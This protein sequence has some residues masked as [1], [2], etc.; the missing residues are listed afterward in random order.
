LP[1]LETLAMLNVVPG[2]EEEPE[3]FGAAAGLLLELP[4][5]PAR[6]AA[7]ATAPAA[8]KAVFGNLRIDRDTQNGAQRF[9]AVKR[10]G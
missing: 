9:S 3:G 1:T 4:P 5:Q 7:A 8:T 2:F 6:S 10:P